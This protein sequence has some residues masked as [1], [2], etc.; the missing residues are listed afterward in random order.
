[1]NISKKKLHLFQDFVR[2][3]KKTIAESRRVEN[4]P[5]ILLSSSMLE[6]CQINLCEN[7]KKYM[8][9]MGTYITETYPSFYGFTKKGKDLLKELENT[10]ETK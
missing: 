1:M 7:F 6:D 5:W 4:M 10:K 3:V 9:L 8:P 2:D